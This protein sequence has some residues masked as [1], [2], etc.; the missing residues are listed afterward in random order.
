MNTAIVFVF[1][2][3]NQGTF[4]DNRKKLEHLDLACSVYLM[5]VFIFISIDSC[6]CD[7]EKGLSNNSNWSLPEKAVENSKHFAF[8]FLLVCE[9]PRWHKSVRE[10][11]KTDKVNLKEKYSDKKKLLEMFWF[12]ENFLFNG[13]S[14]N[15]FWKETRTML[16][17]MYWKNSRINLKMCGDESEGRWKAPPMPW[18]GQ[19]FD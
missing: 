18:W 10:V 3:L 9:L 5:Q 13:S 11:T 8:S 12:W 2:G 1:W 14:L 7:L 4:W 17:R 6:I 19:W 15:S 16:F